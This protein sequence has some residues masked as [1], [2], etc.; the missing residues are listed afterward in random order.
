MTRNIAMVGALALVL[1][2]CGGGDDEDGVASLENETTTTVEAT[3]TTEPAET[4]TTLSNAEQTEADLL[5]FSQCMRDNGVPDFPDATFDADGIPSFGDGTG[6]ADADG[7]GVEPEVVEEAFSSCQ[8]LIADVVFS[9]LPEDTTELEDRFLEFAQC[10]RDQ[11]VDVP[12]PDFSE[13]L[14]GAGAAG[15]PFG[16]LDPNDPDFVAASEECSYIFEGLLPGVGSTP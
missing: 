15:G 2:A 4:T 7:F 1:A 16:D 5:A 12:D 10:M 9:F 13:G 11:G 8:D 14:F 6:G 3:G